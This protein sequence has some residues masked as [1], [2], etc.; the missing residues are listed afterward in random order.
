MADV[1]FENI[2]EKVYELPKVIVIDEE[3]A[4]DQDCSNSL[5]TFI[6]MRTLTLNTVGAAFGWS[7]RAMDELVSHALRVL[8]DKSV[9]ARWRM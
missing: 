4:E 8:Q 6:G 5:G 2:A 9:H 1:G 3:E 7:P